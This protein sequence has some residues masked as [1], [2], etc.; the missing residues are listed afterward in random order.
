[1]NLQAHPDDL[2]RHQGQRRQLVEL[3]QSKGIS[4]ERVLEAIGLI[5]RHLFLD[6]S[7]EAFAYKDAAFPIR[8]S[9]TISQPY[10]VAFQSQMLALPP[11]SKVLEIGTG[12]G[13]Q[14]A[15]L[16]A[17]GYKVYSI[18]RQ[19]EL[20]DFSQR[21]L[22]PLGVNIT[23]RLGDGYK[24]M[25]SF[26]PYEGILVTAAAPDIPK[27]LLSQLSIGGKLLIPVGPEGEEQV[28]H[29]IV[30]KS[31]KEFE[32]QSLGNFRFVPMLEKVAKGNL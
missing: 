22:L 10:T 15:V 5:P 25:E 19:K 4:D 3:L 2:P 23:Q 28:M 24:G 6:S 30:R 18:E 20:F 16:F 12:S 21:I 29:R 17:M 9:Q 8:A 26:A 27:A 13:Y 11:G 1:M 14:A 31:E 32:R 7:F